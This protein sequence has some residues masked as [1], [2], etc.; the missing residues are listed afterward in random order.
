[1][2][3]VALLAL[4]FLVVT[5]VSVSLPGGRQA[6]VQTIRDYWPTEEWQFSTPEQQGMRSDTLSRIGKAIADENMRIH[7][8]IVV[9]HGYIIYENYTAYYGP[10]MTHTIQSCTKSFI[11]ALIGIAIDMEYIDNVSQKIVSFFPEYTIAN[12]DL[13]KANITLE[14]CL[15]MTSGLEWHEVDIPY[16]DPANDLFAMYRSDNM[17]GYVLNRSMERDPGTEYSYNSGGIELLGGALEHA[18]GYSIADFAEEFLFSRIG[19]EYFS[20]YRQPPSYQYVSGGGLY[21]TPRDMA[22]FG[23]LFLNN[24]TWNGTQVISQ[25]WVKESTQPRVS[26]PYGYDYAYTWWS[27]P[28]YSLYEATG[29]YEQKIY[30]LPEE[31]IVVVFTGN[32][33]DDAFHPTD[34]FVVNYVLPAV[35]GS[36][37]AVSWF[38]TLLVVGIAIAGVTALAAVVVTRRRA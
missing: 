37:S 27:I 26:T 29:H 35:L 19:I 30:V 21:L 1:M 23:F 12:M 3:A 31:D 13:R 10:G 6:E 17:W 9:R 15:T 2:K 7:S 32:V 22:R 18:T 11:S 20:W 14:H 34:H 28:G 8:V 38:E 5:P 36:G 16:E 4:L 24:G 25:Q 33:P